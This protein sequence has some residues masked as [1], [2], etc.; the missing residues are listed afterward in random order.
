MKR[1]KKSRLQKAAICAVVAVVAG[2][3]VLIGQFRAGAARQD[4]PIQTLFLE[5]T[6]L[7]RTLSVSGVVQ[8]AVEQNVFSTM[9]SPVEEIF[10]TVGDRVEV[11]DVLARLDTTRLERDIRQAELNLMSAE[12]SRS[13]EARANLNNVAAAHT[14]LAASQISLERQTLATRNALLDLQE[15]LAE[16]DEPFDS[17]A[18]DRMIED[19]QLN[20]ARRLA[21]YKD[22][23]SDLEAHRAEFD[24]FHLANAVADARINL[25]RRRT[26]LY[27]AREDLEYEIIRSGDGALLQAQRDSAIAAARRVLDSAELAY[28]DARRA[29]ERAGQDL[30]RARENADEAHRVAAGALQN[31]RNRT[32][33]AAADAQRALERTLA[34]KELSIQDFIEMNDTRL[35]GARR[36]HEDSQAQMRAAQVSLI[37]SQQALD[38]AEER[39]ETTGLNVEVQRL[40]LERLVQQLE[41]GYIRATASGIIAE[42][43]ANVGAMPGGILFV[44]VDVDDL[45]VSANVREHSLLEIHLGQQGYV[46]TVATGDRVY[47][48][49]VDFISPRSVSPPGS[50]SVEFEIRASLLDS[51]TD[52]RIGMNAFLNVV[53][54][55][56]ENVF[57]VPL[58]AVVTDQGGQFVYYVADGDRRRI[59]VSTGLRT[60]THVEV[61]GVGLAEGLELMAR[62]G[63][64]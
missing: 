43:F 16:V 33:D 30:L 46:T 10:V 62:P 48:G 1:R 29:Y 41:E 50:T 54:E 57:V 20:L 9:Q 60:S 40:N 63:L 64:G 59:P 2:S 61:Y 4:A 27:D 22:A 15:A 39:P 49:V 8:S 47:Y 17:R 6:D 52:I 24:D 3:A 18:H 14:S 21:D 13:E 7:T 28:E 11:G 36:I 23:V 58:T 35:Q 26:A 19:A 12:L 32:R 42:V 53:I 55:T 34:D 44:I 37:S 5:R 31:A 56:R 25:E 51:D 45:F 38:Q